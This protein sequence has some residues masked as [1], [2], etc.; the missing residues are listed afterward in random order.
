MESICYSDIWAY[1]ILWRDDFSRLTGILESF[2]SGK[3]IITYLCS[4]SFSST[5]LLTIIADYT[6]LNQREVEALD[7]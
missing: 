5:F 6:W 3:K 7:L 1:F 4:V 2:L